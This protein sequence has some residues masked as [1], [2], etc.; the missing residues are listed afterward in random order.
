MLLLNLSELLLYNI[1]NISSFDKKGTSTPILNDDITQNY[2][3]I[4]KKD[5]KYGHIF[6]NVRNINTN[7]RILLT[8]QK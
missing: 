3:K 5:L 2:Q 7:V 1:E 8:K 4:N 6:H